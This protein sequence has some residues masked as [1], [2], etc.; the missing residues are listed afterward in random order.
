MY[1]VDT[2]SSSWT[3]GNKAMVTTMLS[4]LT[5]S[6]WWPLLYPYDVGG[7][8]FEST[9]LTV[10]STCEATSGATPISCAGADFS[11]CTG[12][13]GWNL[14]DPLGLYF[15]LP[16]DGTITCNIGCG[17]EHCGNGV[18]MAF[19][20]ATG[21]PS[22]NG[23]APLDGQIYSMSH[24]IAEYLT[25]PNGSSGW[26]CSIGTSDT[27]IADLCSGGWGGGPWAGNTSGQPYDVTISGN[28]YA[29][30]DL[31]QP[32]LVNGCYA[33]PP[34]LTRIGTFPSPSCTLGSGYALQTL[35]TGWCT[36]PTC[37]DGQ[38]DGWETDVDCGG[39]CPNYR[40]S[41]PLSPPSSGLCAS[42]KHCQYS[43]DCVSGTCTG[44]GT[45]L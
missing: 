10:A 17:G 14:T 32:G 7:Q 39:A 26:R 43:T 31:W 12:A 42:G 2:G 16:A 8:T 21:N 22:P 29:L 36:T 23:N 3:S 44:G 18:V 4:G 45:C 9:T 37:S 5:S 35:P 28:H 6:T 27:E 34:D 11:A 24:E 19:Q 30:T 38:R 13:P 20:T 41:G 33:Q 1:F 15:Y 40:V 25:D